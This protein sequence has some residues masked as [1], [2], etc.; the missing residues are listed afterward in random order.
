MT[1]APTRNLLFDEPS[2]Y[3]RQ[4]ADNP[5]HWLPWG[6]VA[7]DLARALD[8]PLLLSIGY[9]ACHWC[10]VMNR[11]SFAD[12]ATA[13]LMNARFVCVKVDREERPD[14]D[15]VYQAAHQLL[16]QQPGGW[17][18]T[19]F[20]HPGSELPFFSGTYFPAD[21]R[22]GLPSFADLLRRVHGY[23]RD[24]QPAIAD[25]DEALRAAFAQLAASHGDGDAT[26]DAAPL[27]EARDALADAFD[28]DFGGFGSAP[29]FPQPMR[30]ERLLRTWRHTAASDAPDVDSLFMAV[31]TLKRLALGGINDQL[32]GGFFRYSTDAYWMVPHY[33]KMLPDSAGLIALYAQ[34]WLAT[35][36]SL[37]R[38]IA[39]DTVRWALR[40]MRSDS[41]GFC[42]SLDA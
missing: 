37:F 19:A 15:Q 32:G 34:A 12:P 1:D 18:L 39:Q 5:V 13:E 11:E 41:G 30:I 3:L 10:H 24:H 25:Q 31:Y 26:L 14:V 27:R 6:R 42:S 9:S 23:Y 20:V 22:H 33:E 7:L 29:K 2:P 28:K 16:T 17:P 40:E 8:R 21:A 36:E 4:H 38:R 35:G